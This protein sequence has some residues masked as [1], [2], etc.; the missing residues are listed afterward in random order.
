MCLEYNFIS[1][2]EENFTNFSLDSFIIRQEVF[3]CWRKVNGEYELASVHYVDDKDL[4]GLRVLAMTILNGI[5]RGNA[6]F[7]A[8][9]GEKIIGFAYLVGRPF[10]SRKQYLD[11]AEFYVSEP[12]R[13]QGL[14]RKLF[15]MACAEAKKRGAEKLYISAHSA[16]ESAAAYKSYGCVFAEEPDYDHMIKEPFDLQLEF[17]LKTF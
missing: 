4:N 13:R 1:L 11:L 10:G 17:D 5:S 14:G 8:F 15:Y 7:G 9:S 6:A 16:E 2:N 3:K 12:Y